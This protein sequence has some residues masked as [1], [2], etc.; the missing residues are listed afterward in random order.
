[1]E[2]MECPIQRFLVY[3]SVEKGVTGF[4]SVRDIRRLIAKLIY[5]IRCCIFNE[6]MARCNGGLVENWVN[7][8]LGG[9]MIYARDL[10]QTP[11][12]FLVEM[13]HFAASVAGKAGALPQVSW[14]GIESGMTLTIR[15]KKVKFEQLRR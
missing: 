1:M 10:L 15:G 12:G 9:L 8:E 4:V 2:V 6:L 5:G 14:L 7:R 11:F 13:M 3:A